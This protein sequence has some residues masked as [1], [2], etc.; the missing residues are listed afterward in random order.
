MLQVSELRKTFG[1]LKAVDG[2]SFEVSPGEIYGLLGPNGAGKTTTINMIAGLLASA[3]GAV[4]LDGRD[5]DREG[6]RF[7]GV[8]PQETAL[9]EDLSGR[10][11]LSF[12]C[13]LYGHAGRELGRRVERILERVGLTDRAGDRVKKYS[14]GMKRRLNLAVGLVHEPRL[15]LLDE[16]TVGIDPQA[17]VKI[18]DL[19]RE[20][21]ADGTAVLYTT[22]YLEEAETLCSRIG[23]MDHG[24]ILAE[25][26]VA[27]L[28]RILGEGTLV[29]LTGEFDTEDVKSFLYERSGASLVDL[30]EDRVMVSIR[31]VE[32]GVSAFLQD[33]YGGDLQVEGVAL[34]EPNLND[35]FIKLTGRELRD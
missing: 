18:L 1:D 16:P 27:E 32:R 33:V 31:D 3:S 29:V 19:V 15:L 17:R 34:K 22:H 7:L 23:I 30:S 13:G 35:L 21:A 4:R 14:G 24:R 25:G 12:W 2:I 6:R 8:V 9:Y 26:T 5:L 11:N 20:V 10:E 28:K